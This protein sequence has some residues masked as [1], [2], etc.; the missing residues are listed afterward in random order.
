[1][2]PLRGSEPAPPSN[3][4]GT[5]PEAVPGGASDSH[6]HTYASLLNKPPT[7]YLGAMP[8]AKF[9]PGQA[10]LSGSFGIDTTN[11]RLV[12][13]EGAVRYASVAGAVV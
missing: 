4:D 10:G 6:R 1:M 13:Y 12:W 8:F 9:A 5:P 7:T 3:D 2:R 11:H